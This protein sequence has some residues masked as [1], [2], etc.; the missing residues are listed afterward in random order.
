LVKPGTSASVFSTPKA[1]NKLPDSPLGSVY[2]SFSIVFSFWS[3]LMDS[4]ILV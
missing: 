3:I 2:F 1:I 4:L